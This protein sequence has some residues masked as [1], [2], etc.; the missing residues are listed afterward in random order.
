VKGFAHWRNP[1]AVSPLRSDPEQNGGVETSP[2]RRKGPRKTRPLRGGVGSAGAFPAAYPPELGFALL[3]YAVAALLA[4]L[5]CAAGYQAE[6]G[7]GLAP[8]LRLAG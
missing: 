4:L 7:L 1:S 5:R 6:P 8:G 3:R 2:S